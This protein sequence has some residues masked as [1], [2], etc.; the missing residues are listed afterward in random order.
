MPD[1]YIYIYTYLTSGSISNQIR[2][3]GGYKT[4]AIWVKAL[5]PDAPGSMGI[6]QGR[7]SLH[8][9][10]SNKKSPALLANAQGWS[11]V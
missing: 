7:D 11:V 6:L 1:M 10:G 4:C 5:V 3:W 9:T 2:K 8:A